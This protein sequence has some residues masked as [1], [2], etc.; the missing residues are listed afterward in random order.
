M[1]AREYNRKIQIW[2]K[3]F[4]TDQYGG[5]VSTDVF[6]KTIWAKITTNAG[7]KFVDFGIQDFKNPVMFSV[8]GEK[9]G[10]DYTENYFIQYND[11][12][13]FIKGVE[14]RS[15]ENMEIQLLTDSQ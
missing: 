7:T 15:I 10:I 8:R 9:N 5:N 4:V 2:R 3:T 1:L 13:Y 14:N 11:V 12:K 6:V